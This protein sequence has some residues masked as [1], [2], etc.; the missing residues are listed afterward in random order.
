MADPQSLKRFLELLALC[1][2]YNIPALLFVLLSKGMDLLY[3]KKYS[4]LKDGIRP[5]RF[6]VTPLIIL[7]GFVLCAIL[8]ALMVTF[9]GTTAGVLMAFIVLPWL[10]GT[11][12]ELGFVR[13]DKKIRTDNGAF[14]GLH[15]ITIISSVL[16]LTE[17]IVY[18]AAELEYLRQDFLTTDLDSD[19]RVWILSAAALLTAL[20][21]RWLIMHF[22]FRKQFRNPSETVPDNEELEEQ[23]T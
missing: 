18:F 11:F 7:A 17:M 23:E 21:I 5:V 4:L 19:I 3:L 22:S 16:L 10:A 8:Q 6:V 20:V 15:R 14:F 1:G 9:L 12:L 2:L 13:F